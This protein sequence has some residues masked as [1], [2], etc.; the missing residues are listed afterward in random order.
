[1]TDEQRSELIR[2][3]GEVGALRNQTP[4]RGPGRQASAPAPKNSGKPLHDPLLAP[5]VP[6]L[7]TE[8]RANVG[9]RSLWAFT[10]HDSA[11][12]AQTVA[13]DPEIKARATEVFN[14]AP[15][16][17]RQRFGSIDGVL[18]AMMAT[19][20]FT[21]LN[22]TGFGV[23][24][25]NVSGDEAT[26][27]VQEQHGDGSVRQTPIPMQRFEDGWHVITPSKMVDVLGRYLGNPQLWAMDSTGNK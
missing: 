11:A 12:F 18:Y 2:L 14:S 5:T 17:A 19:P 9:P 7:P 20:G 15:E 4:P 8:N 10:K 26:L 21:E 22:V 25:Q 16:A 13:W 3:R 1:L 23:A 27:S 6:L 24:S